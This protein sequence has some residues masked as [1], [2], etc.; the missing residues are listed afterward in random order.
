MLTDLGALRDMGAYFKCYS[1][2]SMRANDGAHLPQVIFIF[3]VFVLGGKHPEERGRV[4]KTDKA[5]LD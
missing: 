3:W 5:M 1:S 4:D 2:N